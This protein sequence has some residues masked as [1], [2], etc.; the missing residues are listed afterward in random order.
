MDT[1]PDLLFYPLE[2]LPYAATG[3]NEA[4]LYVYDNCGV[5]DPLTYASSFRTGLMLA[6][7]SLT[8]LPGRYPIA[9]EA[10]FFPAPPVRVM[11]YRYGGLVWRVLFRVY[12]ANAS[13]AARVEVIAVRHGAQKPLTR[14]DARTIDAA[15]R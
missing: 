5:D 11:P 15:N 1:A 8:T 13:D 14:K 6:I 2:F 10:K 7:V 3:V 12:E 9:P 4:A